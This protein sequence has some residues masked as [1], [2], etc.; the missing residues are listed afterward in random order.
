MK[1]KK[2][3]N[4]IV[5]SG[6]D[7]GKQGKVSEAYPAENRILVPNINVHKKHQR[8]TKGGEKGKII[9]KAFPIHVSNAM[10]L[11]SGGNRTRVGFKKVGDKKIRVAKTTG[12]E[13]KQ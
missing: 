3:D 1:I 13:I 12:G 7:K 5:I 4:I 2:G 11:D 8:A 10:V 9:D 6:K